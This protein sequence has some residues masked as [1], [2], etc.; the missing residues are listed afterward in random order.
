MTIRATAFL[1]I[2]TMFVF[3][4]NSIFGSVDRLTLVIWASINTALIY[5]GSVN[6]TSVNLNRS[7]RLNVNT[8]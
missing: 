7:E 4:A 1:L 5:L 8:A 3:P 6:L 2:P